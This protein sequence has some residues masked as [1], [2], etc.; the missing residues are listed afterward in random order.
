MARLSQYLTGYL[1]CNRERGPG[2]GLTAS[3]YLAGRIRGKAK[4]YF[5]RYLRSLERAC[6]L[7]GAVTGPSARGAV[8]WY[9]VEGEVTQ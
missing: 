6:K 4:N 7:T 5:A 9:P 3:S 2:N 8:A 1:R